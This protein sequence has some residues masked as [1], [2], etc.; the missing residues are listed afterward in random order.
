[1][2]KW[3]LSSSSRD[4]HSNL[5][6][7]SE[8]F[9]KYTHTHTHTHT[10]IYLFLTVLGFCCC[11]SFSLVVESW[12]YSLAAMHRLLI[13]V[14]SCCGTWDLEHTDF[15]SCGLR[16]LEHRLN[17]CSTQ[18]VNYSIACEIFPDQG[19][20]L[21]LLQSQVVLY[22]WAIKEALW[23]LKELGPDPGGEW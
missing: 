9:F 22:H 12:R 19:S 14:A 16:A 8:T 10:H 23:V 20:N 18:A 2:I 3:H 21:C 17:S 1:M 15:S 4:I 6:Y 7:I 11:M 5:M 13:V